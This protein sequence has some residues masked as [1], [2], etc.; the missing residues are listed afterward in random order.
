MCKKL[1]TVVLI[2]SFT[3]TILFTALLHTESARGDGATTYPWPSFRHDLLNTGAATDSG[4]PTSSTILWMK[5]RE[6]RPDTPGT[7]AGSRGP[8]VVDKGMIFTAG[9]GVIQANSQLDGSLVWSKTFTW[10]PPEEPTGA[11]SDWCYNDIPVLEGNTGK[12]YVSDLS[13]CPSW[14]FACTTDETDCTSFS[15]INP[16]SFPEGYA[17]FLTGPT[18]D[19]SYGDNG[20]VIFGTFDGR[21]ISLDMDNGTTLWEKT[22]YKDTGGPNNGKPWYNQKF[23][24]HLSPPSIYSGKVYIGTFLPSFYA[25]F[26]PWAYTSD[27]SWPTIGNDATNYWVGRDGYFYALDQDDGSIL[28]TWDPRGCGVTNVP[29]VQNGKVFI[30]ADTATDYHYGQFAAVDA[31]TGD[32]LWQFGTIPLAQ[33]GSQAISGNTIFTPGGDGA[34]WALDVNTAQVQWTYHA[35]FNVRGHTA[36][37]SSPAVDE[38]NGWVIGIADTGHMFVLNKDTGRVVKE[39]FLGVT[40]WK[41]FDPHPDSGYW[42]PGPSGLA[43]VPSQGLLYV[44]ATDYD[45]AWKGMGSAGREKLF[46]YDYLSDPNTL[47]LLWEYQFCA[48][49][50]C[51]EEAN[52]YLVRGHD[53]YVVAWYSMG[54]PALADGHVYFASHNGKIYCFGSSYTSTTTTTGGQPCPAEVIYGVNSKETELLGYFKD[55]VL[56][57]TPEGRTIIELYYMWSPAIVDALSKD[58]AF[59]AEVKEIVGEFFPLIGSD[60][61]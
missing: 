55:S 31:D 24:W 53:P 37:C 9:T 39:A 4:Y 25:I 2:S 51:S 3:L 40:S 50:D 28:W 10:Q 38:T 22:P 27:Y 23:A 18:L 26:R 36:L 35:G 49:D 46:C 47:T 16:L 11:P 61:N 34:L 42:I 8:S 17:Q 6:D 5:D 30:E 29:P 59:K 60:S 20:T 44:A 57:Q 7:A 54:S 15:L 1:L 32:E 43:I 21:V 13:N 48:D 58:K 14:C 12:C 45:R 19:S 56:S 33:G 52:E 41:V